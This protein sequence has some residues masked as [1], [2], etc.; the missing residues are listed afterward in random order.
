[1]DLNWI[2]FDFFSGIGF[3]LETGG[4]HVPLRIIFHGQIKFGFLTDAGRFLDFSK[5]KI[6]D[7]LSIG[8]SNIF[9]SILCN[10]G[11]VILDLFEVVFHEEPEGS[12]RILFF[13]DGGDPGGRLVDGDFDILVEDEVFVFESDFLIF[14]VDCSEEI[15]WVDSALVF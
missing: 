6:G 15:E 12:N 7:F 13:A 1:M 3:L 11:D 9:N 4:G 2:S 8:D 5:E 14:G 10:F